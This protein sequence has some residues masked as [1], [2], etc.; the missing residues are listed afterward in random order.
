MSGVTVREPDVPVSTY[1]L[2]VTAEWTLA[3]AAR[4]VPD[5]VALGVDWV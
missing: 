5:L 2:Q 1:R 4:L 3:D